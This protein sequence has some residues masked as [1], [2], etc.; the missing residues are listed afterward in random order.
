[1]NS[2]KKIV[3]L[4]Y[5]GVGKT[6]LLIRFV[7][8]QF[9]EDYIVTIGVQVKKKEIKLKNGSTLSFIIWDLEGNKSVEEIRESY[10]LGASS[11]IYV[12]DITR[13]ETYQNINNEINYLKDKYPEVK[14]KIIGNKKDLLKDDITER[15]WKYLKIPYDILTSAKTGENIELFFNSLAVDIIND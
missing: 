4:G 7:D 6:S 3:I 15:E 8:N 2:S 10:L 11:F 14:I 12:F 13:K 9:S 1:M 5:F